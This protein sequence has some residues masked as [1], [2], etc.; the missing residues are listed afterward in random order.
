MSDAMMPD[1]RT[2]ARQRVMESFQE[3]LQKLDASMLEDL[4]K[5]DGLDLIF[6]Q[7][8]LERP[9]EKD[10]ALETEE[11]RKSMQ[12]IPNGNYPAKLG[13]KT[14]GRIVILSTDSIEWI[15]A[16]RDYVRLH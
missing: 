14:N 3:A 16:E 6:A 1:E 9:N 8:G 13:F 10:S 2:L 12:R 4:L 7:L 15:Q 5:R 11:R